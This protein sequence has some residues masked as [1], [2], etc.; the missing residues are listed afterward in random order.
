MANL[1]AKQFSISIEGF[2]KKPVVF[3]DVQFEVVAQKVLEAY[4]SYGLRPSQITLRNGDDAFNYDISFVLFNGNGTFRISSEKLEIN[5][6]NIVTDKDFEVVADCIAKLYDHVPVPETR[7]LIITGHAQTVMDSIEARQG[8][9]DTYANPE[10]QIHQGGTVIYTQC[11]DWK[12]EIRLLVDRS[13]VYP[14]G[15]FLM[16]TTTF[17]DGKLSRGILK[18]LEDACREAA[19]KI[20]L[21]FPPN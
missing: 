13:E 17:W 9:L 16:W 7:N 10:K 3:K 11:Q 14:E 6:Q 15:L 4:G 5:F 12:T 2:V 8:Y 19:A 18:A 1:R 20:D 21:Q